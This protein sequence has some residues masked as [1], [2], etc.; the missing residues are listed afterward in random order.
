MDQNG[1]QEASGLLSGRS[2]TSQDDEYHEKQARRDEGSTSSSRSSGAYSRPDGDDYEFDS[3]S[4]TSSAYPSYRV[5]SAFARFLQSAGASGR[6]RMVL[7]LASMVLVSL[8]FWGFGVH[9][10]LLKEKEKFLSSSHS[11]SQATTTEVTAT[12]TVVPTPAVT[13]A[14]LPASW[15]ANPSNPEDDLRV[16]LAEPTTTETV[17]EPSA[18]ADNSVDV[19]ASGNE[20]DS[21]LASDAGE[22]DSEPSHPAHSVV[23]AIVTLDEHGHNRKP[24]NTSDFC[25]T[26][27]VDNAGKY[28]PK[29]IPADKRHKLTSGAP[30]GGWKKPAG[31]KVIA[32][33]FY[34]RK[35][36]VDILDCYL[37]QNLVSNGGY[38][39]EVR[40]MVKTTNED[41]IEWLRAF[42]KNV[43]G[44]TYQD[45]DLC[46]TQNGYGCIWEYAD[47]DDTLYI[48]VDDDI[49]YIHQDAIPQLV[50]TRLVVTQPYAISAQLVNSP[51]SGLQQYHSGAIHPFIPDP[52]S[53]PTR[54]PG[55]EW[56]P[57]KWG[58]L[59]KGMKALTEGAK[60]DV[61]SPYEGHPWVLMSSSLE[62]MSNLIRTP[63]G[64]WQVH[65]GN[66][67][68]FGPGWKSWAIAA[69]QEYS[70][71]YNIELNEMDRYHFGRPLRY[72]K[73]PPFPVATMV[74]ER[75]TPSTATSSVNG[76]STAVSQSQQQH[77]QRSTIVNTLP[78][79]GGENLF[80]MQYN[81]YNLNFIAVWGRD[82][83][84]GLPIGD[85]EADM[86]QFI[87]RRLG[88]PFVIDTRAIVAHN[89]F[90][91]QHGGIRHSDLLDRW[92]ALSN[93]LACKPDNL[94]VPWDFRCKGF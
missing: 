72:K 45:L 57:S 42:V 17:S 6:R 30:P 64:D 90:F 62:D 84:L 4:P 79:V 77:Q 3:T 10:M 23:P 40:F 78:N 8:L 31:L 12:P 38:L 41:D 94:K 76:K 66:D 58:V 85:D 34:G 60:L 93:E 35:R 37:R 2:R 68:A 88:R 33:V 55:E 13:H 14:E 49:L 59:A 5:K 71:L 26:W 16:T 47:E 67:P 24:S 52:Y 70:L 63:M 83:K 82:V 36:N 22:A 39:D 1:R 65:R 80:D 7:G 21:E 44:Y 53:H 18:A 73:A 91:T 89:S 15:D 28:N 75:I 74:P 11:G 19:P 86:S 32:M 29:K 51:V 50:H 69:Q 27:P 43:D 56:R 25:T 92:R 81:R 48:K 20:D 46:T 61:E 87:P 54:R 9:T